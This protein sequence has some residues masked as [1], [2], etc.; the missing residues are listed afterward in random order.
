MKKKKK[1]EENYVLLKRCGSRSWRHA[2]PASPSGASS[3]SSWSTCRLLILDYDYAHQN[4]LTTLFL[5][6]FRD[7]SSISGLVFRHICSSAHLFQV[8]ASLPCEGT[9]SH[10]CR[11]AFPE[12]D[13][14]PSNPFSKFEN[15]DSPLIYAGFERGCQFCRWR[16]A[17]GGGGL[18][19]AW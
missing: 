17:A 15:Q 2:R 13:F 11:G 18:S 12:K 6:S 10:W 7:L 1:K 3:L 16:A 8:R 9:F 4:M 19:L 5:A 14:V